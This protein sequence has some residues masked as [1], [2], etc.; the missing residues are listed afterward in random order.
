LN[1]HLLWSRNRSPR[2][3]KS[4]KIN[5]FA[6][7]ERGVRSQN[8]IKQAYYRRLAR[9]LQR[10]NPVVSQFEFVAASLPRQVAA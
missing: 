5:A 7:F 6:A 10:E 8:L 4:R 3:K 2:D 9:I 1:F